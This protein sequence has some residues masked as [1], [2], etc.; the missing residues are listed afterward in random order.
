MLALGLVLSWWAVLVLPAAVLI[1]FAFAAAGMAATT[2][3]RSWQDFDWVHAG[4][5]ADVPALGD[6][7]PAVDVPDP[8]P[9]VVRWSPLYRASTS[10]ARSRPGRCTRGCAQGPLSA[11]ARDRRHRG[12]VPS[13]R[14]AAPHLRSGATSLAVGSPA[15]VAPTFPEDCRD[16][17]HPGPGQARRRRRVAWWVRCSA[18]S[19]A[20]GFT[21]VAGGAAHARPRPPP[22]R[23]TPS[24]PSKPFFGSL[25]TSSRAARCS[26]P[27]SRADA[28]RP[29]AR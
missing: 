5:A 21:L 28:I 27:S 20:S 16:R 22:R 12:G 6:V 19:S 18:G 23:T 8:D 13:P 24:T 2:Y 11:R 14:A 4:D 26:R 3:M 29:G 10:S 17:A 1:G 15:P 9:A 7:L 25:V